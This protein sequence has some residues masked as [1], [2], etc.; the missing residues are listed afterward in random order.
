MKQPLSLKLASPIGALILSIVVWILC[1]LTPF[2]IYTNE[3]NPDAYVL[4]AGYII[5][6]VAGTLVWRK[7]P[8]FNPG[9][10]IESVRALR[11]GFTILLLIAGTGLALRYFD[12]FFVKHVQDYDSTSAFRLSE[13][14]EGAQQP[15]AL[16]AVS[17]LLYPV[18]LACYVLSLYLYRKLFMWQRVLAVVALLGYA[19]YTVLQGGRAA[20][21]VAGI[22]IV[23]A[24]IL[25]G[26]H[27]PER[28]LQGARL[29]GMVVG[30][31]LGA[32]AF[33]G[34]SAYIVISR[35]QAVGI[36]NPATLLDAAEK[37]RG[38]ILREPYYT[39]VKKGS[40]EVSSAVSTGSSLAYYFN[41]GF[42]NFSELYNEEQGRRPLFGVMQFS[43]VIRFL[44]T[45]G[46][47]VPSVEEAQDRIPHPGLFYTFFGTVL[48]DWGVVGSLIYCLLFG[49]FVQ[50]LW[51]KA[52]A[53]SLLCLMLYPFFACV[54]AYF[55]L[56]DM[57]VGAYGLFTITAILLSV[58][59]IH[60]F[61]LAYKA[62][63]KRMAVPLRA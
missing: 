45:L 27:D 10:R 28:R 41:H 17:V 34:Y 53:G 51:L 16:S 5:A 8:P 46:V 1:F 21:A 40:P 26:I 39:M 43:P 47:K 44:D 30:I 62:R 60:F 58:G 37:T 35:V 56:A 22:M 20:L 52:Q 38:F 15:G 25:R 13:V 18:A 42:F 36:D 29:R 19:G 11:V 61:G 12:L 32:I 49:V 63:A 23:A 31:V 55:P 9:L 33:M 50:A 59:L 24:L 14:E 3:Q 4:I 54:I 6:F 57:I 48:M 7:L 2:N